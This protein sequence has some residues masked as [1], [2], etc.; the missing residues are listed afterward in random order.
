VS[1]AITMLLTGRTRVAMTALTELSD[2][3]DG[4]YLWA[5]AAL[6]ASP[7]APNVLR[8]STCCRDTHHRALRALANLWEPKL[9][10]RVDLGFRAGVIGMVRALRGSG[11]ARFSRLVRLVIDLLVLRGRRDHSKDVEIL[12]LRH[13]LAVLRRQMA[14]LR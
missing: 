7:G 11:V 3:V 14:L 2:R 1:D 12:V 13:E 4:C 6:S 9:V 10:R 8:R 5:F